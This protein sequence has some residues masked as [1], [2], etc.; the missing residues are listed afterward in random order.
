MLI[1]KSKYR[2]FLRNTW[3]Q[4]LL[5]PL[6]FLNSERDKSVEIYETYKDYMSLEQCS[7]QQALSFTAKYYHLSKPQ[8]KKIL[9]NLS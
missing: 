3:F 8:L 2:R 1:K 4:D 6:G 9:R 7:S 5:T